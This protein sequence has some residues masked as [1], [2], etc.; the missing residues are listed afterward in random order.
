LVLNLSS[1]PAFLKHNV[2]VIAVV[3]VV[4]VVVVIVELNKVSSIYWV[5]I[6]TPLVT[7][8]ILLTNPRIDG[9][10]NLSTICSKYIIIVTVP[11]Y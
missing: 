3:A 2:V 6:T 10:H 8:I 7:N 1:C 4:I 5:R 11:K 9:I